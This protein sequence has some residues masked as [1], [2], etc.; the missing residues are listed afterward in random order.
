MVGEEVGVS[1]QEEEVDKRAE[2]VVVREES[3]PAGSV[4]QKLLPQELWGK[5]RPRGLLEQ[6]LEKVV[7]HDLRF[8]GE[9]RPVFYVPVR[10]RLKKKFG[11]TTTT[12][13]LSLPT[14]DLKRIRGNVAREGVLEAIRTFGREVAKGPEG[15]VMES[16]F[17][18]QMPISNE[19]DVARREKLMK[20][21]GEEPFEERDRQV[22]SARFGLE[23]GQISTFDEIGKVY[24]ISVERVRQVEKKVLRQLYHLLPHLRSQV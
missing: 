19:A 15:W 5:E 1:P 11:V 6:S 16:V 20:I 22:L 12:E 7:E 10:E 23:T 9:F 2:R 18:K 13:L 4:G 8:P 24:N 3:Y 17:G 21:L 14:S